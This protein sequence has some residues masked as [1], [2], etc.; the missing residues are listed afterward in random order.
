MLTIRAWSFLILCFSCTAIADATGSSHL[1]RRAETTYADLNDAASIEGA[2]DAGSIASFRN[3]G[4][5]AWER[6]VRAKSDQLRIEL[7]ALSGQHLAPADARVVAVLRRKLDSFAEAPAPSAGQAHACDDAGR[8]ELDYAGLRAALVQCFVEKGNNIAFGNDSIDRASALGLL[9]QLDDAG[10]RKALFLAFVPLWTAV[11][12]KDEADSAYRRLVALSAAD[13]AKHG[14]PLDAAARSL[15]VQGADIERW[16]EQILEAWRSVDAGPPVEPWD[17]RYVTGEAD[18][19]LAAAIPRESF[20]SINERFYLDLG[21]DLKGLGVIYDLDPRPGK[22][23][24]AYTD[25]VVHGRWAGGRWQP[26]VARVL[27]TYS[28]GGLSS[29]NELVHE[30][31]HAV[32]ISAIRNRPA[33][34]DWP[35]DLFTEA[36]A[37]VSSWSTYEPAWQRRYL[38]RSAPERASLRALYGSVMLDVAWALFEIR[39]LEAP[40]SDPNA[41]WTDLAGRYLNIA[42]HP[43]LSWWAV[44]VQLVD[45]PGYMVNYGLGAVLTADLR[46]HL[47]KVLGSIDTGNPRWYPLLSRQLLRFG[48][49]RDTRELLKRFLGRP[50]SPRPLLAELA[51][52]GAAP[53]D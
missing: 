26:T 27:A 48:S 3:R 44:R 10:Q 19:L 40:G 8:H 52:M 14:S 32:H 45:L 15:G 53:S 34:V 13:A 50:V 47:K 43:E 22:S 28:R 2:I 21:A 31:G 38:G 23:S 37:D 35:E 51:R 17:Y 41:V 24:V 9:S 16:L 36:F 25:F 42:P 30:N 11:N 29:L 4:R 39:M 5:D 46:E 6:I 1:V 33:Y 7:V 49:E 18:R 20:E 12:G